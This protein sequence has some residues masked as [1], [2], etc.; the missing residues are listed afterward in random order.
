ME[1]HHLVLGGVAKEHP[2][3]PLTPLALP[4]PGIWGGG[5]RAGGLG[6]GLGRLE[7]EDWEEGLCWGAG[8][9]FLGVRAWC[10]GWAGLGGHWAVCGE[11]SGMGGAGG[12]GRK[13]KERKR[14]EVRK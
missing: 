5:S 4:L 12:E 9:G 7:R 8:M 3:L 2:K 13:W 10:E 1:L 6:M 14:R 11:V